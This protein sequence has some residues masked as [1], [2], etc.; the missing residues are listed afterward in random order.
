MDGANAELT[1]GEDVA[2]AGKCKSE[3]ERLE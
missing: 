1:E 2:G 3:T